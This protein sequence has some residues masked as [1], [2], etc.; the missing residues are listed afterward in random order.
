[1][2]ALDLIVLSLAAFRLA[3]MVALEDGPFDIFAQ[4]RGR[5]DPLQTTW[6][7]RG[8]NCPLCVGFWASLFVFVVWFIPIVGQL[9]I[10]WWAIAGAQTVIQKVIG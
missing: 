10:V 3:H 9:L 6:L 4:F 1:M 8:V 5:I 7:G 2:P